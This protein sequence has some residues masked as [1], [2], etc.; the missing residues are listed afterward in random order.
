VR[1]VHYYAPLFAA[2][3]G[4]TAAIA[5]WS[6]AQAARG[7]E[8]TVLGAGEPCVAGQCFSDRVIVRGLAH[9]GAGRMTLRPRGLAAQLADA[10]LMYL[11]EGWTRSHYAAARQARR[12]GVPYVVMP[13]GVHHRGWRALLR[14]ERLR[15]LAEARMVRGAAALHLFFDAEAVE[16]HSLDP[17]ATYVVLPTGTTTPAEQWTG[18][19]AELIW[20]GRY[21]VEHKGLDLLL[22]ALAGLPPGGRPPLVLRGT[23]YLAGK[24]RVSELV[25]RLGLGAEVTVGPPIGGAEKD[26]LVLQCA[27]YVQPSRWE[28]HSIGLLEALGQGVPCLVSDRMPIAADLLAA[29]A[30]LV[31]GLESRELGAALLRLAAGVPG[32]AGRGRELVSRQFQ[33]EQIMDRF[34]AELATLVLT[35]RTRPPSGG[36]TNTC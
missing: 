32:V 8:V 2:K 21:S 33:W 11:H 26:E 19:R 30:A 31:S 7:H 18:G 6:G 27:G 28:S 34:D 4:V 35:A 14:A 22:E 3:S 15:R 5:A 12:A 24:Q 17:L 23:D 1:I 25:E 36:R 9:S 13:H 20:I 10:D 29:E 16:S